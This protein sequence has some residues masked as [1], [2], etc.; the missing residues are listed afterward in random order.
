MHLN[1]VLLAAVLSI[2]AGQNPQLVV[3]A[4]LYSRVTVKLIEALE[5]ACFKA[6][7]IFSVTVSL[8][9]CISQKYFLVELQHFQKN[10]SFMPTALRHF[11]KCVPTILSHVKDM[12]QEHEKC[13]SWFKCVHIPAFIST[14]LF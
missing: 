10:R 7:A 9:L 4:N 8:S 11:I 12:R 2:L 1:Q 14:F 6:A 13:W 3:C 5:G